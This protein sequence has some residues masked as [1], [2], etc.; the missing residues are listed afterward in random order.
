VNFGKRGTSTP[1]IRLERVAGG[2]STRRTFT[3][4]ALLWRA[5]LVGTWKVSAYVRDVDSSGVTTY[6]W[7]ELGTATTGEPEKTF[8]VPR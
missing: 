3:E 4:A 1:N 5:A 7:V 2:P 6:A 8:E